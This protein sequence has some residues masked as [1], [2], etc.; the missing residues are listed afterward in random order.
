MKD[1][2]DVDLEDGDLLGEIDLLTRLI[3]AAVPYDEHM[4]TAQVDSALG[5]DSSG[6]EEPGIP[7]A[8]QAPDD[9]QAHLAHLADRPADLSA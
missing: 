4:T 3:V 9:H 8:R 6:D 7:Q 5:L 2:F 1:Q